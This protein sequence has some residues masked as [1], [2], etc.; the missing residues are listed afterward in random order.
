M[1]CIKFGSMS[2]KPSK[3]ESSDMLD[4]ALIGKEETVAPKS[5][6]GEVNLMEYS[7]S[8]PY[9]FGANNYM[10][11]FVGLAIN[12]LGFLLMI[13]G[14][15]DDPSEFDKAELFSD[16]RITVAPM[17]IVIGYIIIAYGIMRRSK[18]NKE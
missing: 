6:N 7:Q 17:L 13:G 14:G 3:K 1:I 16:M 10:L 15:A 18:A 12:I 5:K 9:S 8:A 11:L 2:K 4:D